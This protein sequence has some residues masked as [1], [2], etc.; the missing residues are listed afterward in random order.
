MAKEHRRV[1][2]DLYRV[3]DEADILA[4]NRLEY[5]PTDILSTPEDFDWRYAQNPAGQAIISVARDRDSGSVVGFIWIVP[6]YMRVFGEDWL[7]ATGTNLLIH[8]DYR[9]TSA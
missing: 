4:L 3:G 1:V 7:G 9:G 6:L 5:G 2:A 8:P